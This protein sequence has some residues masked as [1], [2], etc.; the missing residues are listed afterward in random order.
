MCNRGRCPQ[1]APT[2]HRDIAKKA[3]PINPCFNDSLTRTWHYQKSPRCPLLLPVI[4]DDEVGLYEALQTE[5]ITC[6]DLSSVSTVHR[7]DQRSPC[8]SN[9]G[10]VL[11]PPLLVDPERALFPNGA[12]LRAAEGPEGLRPEIAFRRSGQ[13]HSCLPLVVRRLAVLATHVGWRYG[14]GAVSGAL[15]R[16]YRCFRNRNISL[17]C[18]WFVGR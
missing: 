15:T 4:Y 16:R 2:R 8:V 10:A 3:P 1:T 13:Q 17:L 18:E 7:Y 9:L 14:A 5:D 11:L 12:G 6:S